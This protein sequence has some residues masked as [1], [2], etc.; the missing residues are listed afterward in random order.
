MFE[1]VSRFLDE[2]AHHLEAVSDSRSMTVRAS[3]GVAV[4]TGVADIA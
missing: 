3:I 1:V 4:T 2:L